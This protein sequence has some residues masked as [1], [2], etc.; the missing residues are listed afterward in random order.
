M[1]NQ[2]TLKD[3]SS[4]ISSEASEDGRL[5]FGWR[6]GRKIGQSGLDHAPVSRFRALDS[7][8]DMPIN[9]TCGPLFNASSPSAALQLSLENRL[10][11]R[12]D[13]NGSV[14]YVLTW[15]TWDM[16]AGVSICRLR[17]SARRT[18]DSGF[19]GWL[20]LT[21]LVKNAA[22][23]APPAGWPTPG[24]P[25]GGQGTG[26]AEL[27]GATYRNK[28][29][30]KVQLSLQGAAKLAGWPTPMA[31]TPKQKGYNAAGNTDSSRKTVELAGWPTPKEQN[32]RGPSIKKDGLWDIA[33]LA[34]WA[35]PKASDVKSPTSHTKGGSS[36]ATQVKLALGSGTTSTSSHA[37][38]KQ[39][40]ALNPS[41]SRWLM[42][43]PVAFATSARHSEDWLLWQALMAPVSAE[44]RAIGLGL[45]ED[46]VT[47]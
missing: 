32:S 17:A 25:T 16:P 18:S 41:H 36:V 15:S 14:E 24:V 8:K 26:H 46:L 30:K 22:V 35:T 5:R 1:S 38:T 44:Q 47:R 34:G 4:V 12:M 13:V 20:T 37:P 33:K 19:G 6:D 2:K 29:G 7:T 9:D 3:T 27:K 43:F 40:G 42:G 45:S 11:A 31:G 28:N 10:R 21:D 23:L 39:R